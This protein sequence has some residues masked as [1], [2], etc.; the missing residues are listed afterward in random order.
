MT[1]IF[2]WILG[3]FAAAVGA[4]GRDERQ[5]SDPE[6]DA[7]LVRDALSGNTL[8]MRRLVRRLLPVVRAQVGYTLRRHWRRPVASDVRDEYAQEVWLAL[9]EESGKRLMAFE[10]DR[11]ASFEGYVGVVTE[12]TVVSILR[13]RLAQKRGGDQ[14]A[15]NPEVMGQIADEQVDPE[16]QV[17]ARS[18][19]KALFAHLDAQLPERGRLVLRALYVDGCS[20]ADAAKALGVNT[21]VVYNW[22]H[23]IRGLAR[24]FG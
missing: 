17:A 2:S 3:L 9:L 12:R 8:A 10:P 4:A 6:A 16:R 13:K 1:L 22:Q 19:A 18:E 5:T 11:G 20:P 7:A 15:V 24:D 23:K 14:K 21:Q